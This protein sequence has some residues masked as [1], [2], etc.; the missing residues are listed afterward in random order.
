MA[1]CFNLFLTA[2]HTP[3]NMK[4]FL[5]VISILFATSVVFGQSRAPKK[6]RDAFA[7]HAPQAWEIKWNGEGERQKKWTVNYLVDSDS[8]LTSYDYKANWLITLKFISIAELPEKV[9][10]SIKNEYMGSEI[11]NAAEMQESGFDGYG[12]A[13]LY[14]KDRWAIAI[15]SEGDVKRRKMS[16]KGFDF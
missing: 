2:N 11:I 3:I 9:T 5:L 12:V 16:S 13:F 8:L 15:T 1:S 4:N 10:T 6:I 14:K 7:L